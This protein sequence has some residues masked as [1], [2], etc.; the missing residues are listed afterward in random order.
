MVAEVSALSERAYS[1]FVRP[2]IRPLV[3]ERTA[4]LGRVFHPLRW[5]RWALSDL[6]PW[7]WPL[8]ALASAVKASRRAAPPDNPYRRA[9]KAVSDAITA[10]LDLYRDLRDATMEALF[11]QIYGPPAALGV[12]EE[13]APVAPAGRAGSARAA[14]GAGCPRRHWHRR[15][16]RGDGP[17]RR[18]DR[19][20][21]GSHPARPAGTGRA[22][23]PQRREAL[24]ASP[25]RPFAASRPS[26]RSSPSWSPSAGC[27]RCRGS[28]PTPRTDGGHWRCWMRRS[29]R[30]NRP[31]SSGSCSTESGPSSVP[32]RPTT[33]RDPPARVDDV[34]WRP[35]DGAGALRG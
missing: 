26:R 34:E 4:E 20:G 31:R 2:F 9:E 22:F 14:A 5:Q 28:S 32:W 19:Q 10:G 17:D 21:G 8:P 11:F 30:W 15:V 25:L 3:N 35:A 13:A 33:R 16:S 7:L 12:A 23:R 24:P 1:L 6:N 18:P 29:R 27:S